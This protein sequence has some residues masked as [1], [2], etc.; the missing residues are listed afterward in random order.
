MRVVRGE[1][2]RERFLAS[3]SAADGTPSARGTN[4]AMGDATV[5]PQSRR[6]DGTLRKEVR[7]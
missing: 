3:A 5:L 4:N 6:P 2:R 1:R 7:A